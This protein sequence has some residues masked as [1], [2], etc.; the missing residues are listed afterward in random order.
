MARRSKI[1]KAKPESDDDKDKVF[2]LTEIDPEFVSLVRAGANRQRSFMVVKSDEEAAK[3]VP[4]EDATPEDKR[5]AQ[6]AR[7]TEYGIEAREDGNLSYPADDPTT[8][9]LYGDPVNLMYPFGGADNKADVERLKNALARFA[10]ARD[11]YQEKAS[12]VKILERIVEAALAAGV[13]VGYQEGD[14]IYEALPAGLRE[15]MTG[16]E[17]GDQEGS[18]KKSD[19]NEGTPG[20]AVDLA[21]WLEGAEEKVSE[22][23]LDL[24]IQAALATQSVDNAAPAQASSKA[25]EIEPAAAPA[26]TKA[27]EEGTESRKRIAD[28]EA[29]LAKARKDNIALRAKAARASAVVGKSSVIL[30]GEVTSRQQRPGVEKQSPS[31]GAFQSG[32]D[33]AAAVALEGR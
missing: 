31:K 18:G 4:G 12:K 22:L 29:E 27:G 20:G 23:S 13:D 21:S 26:V 8:E 3:A 7:A 14:D 11:E 5:A 32:G 25:Q 17:A 1:A 15:R 28:L 16:M 24:A 30:T 10:Q 9:T 19:G 6:Q 33:I 2:R